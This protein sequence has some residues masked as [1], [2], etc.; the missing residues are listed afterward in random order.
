[1]AAIESPSPLRLATLTEREQHIL[2]LLDSGLLWKELPDR[3]GISLSVI[4]KL[5]RSIFRKLGAHNRAEAVN[6]WRQI[7]KQ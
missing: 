4:N 1:M 5:S 2:R 3:L 7:Q 6:H